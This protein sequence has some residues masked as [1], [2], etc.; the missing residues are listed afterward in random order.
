VNPIGDPISLIN[1][2]ASWETFFTVAKW[3]YVFLFAIYLVF[4]LVVLS[5]IRQMLASLNGQLDRAILL[6]GLLQVGLAL[7]ALILA[8]VIL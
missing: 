4:S 1:Q 3:G 2:W 5:Q 6:L 8:I 7:A